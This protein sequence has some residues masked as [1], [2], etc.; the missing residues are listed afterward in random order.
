MTEGRTIAI[1]DVHGCSAALAALVRAI[2]PQR[3]PAR[4]VV[5][6]HGSA[7]IASL[8]SVELFK[9][10]SGALVEVL[11]MGAIVSCCA[12]AVTPIR[13]VSAS[14]TIINFFIE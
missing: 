6:Q 12:N 13:N 9:V 4:K 5:P 3:R 1:G 7:G 10:I 2:D 8:T 11:S 14:I